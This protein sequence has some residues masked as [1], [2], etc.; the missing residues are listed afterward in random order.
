M[1]KVFLKLIQEKI[2]IIKLPNSM[3][4]LSSW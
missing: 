2:D 3:P 1:E 4:K